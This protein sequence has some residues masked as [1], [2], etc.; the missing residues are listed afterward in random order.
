MERE[1]KIIDAS[2]VVKWFSH[3]E[4]SERALKLR[5]EH[6]SGKIL[7]VA[8]ELIFWEVLN[9]LRY[10]ENNES[11]LIAADR[12]LWDTQLHI[13]KIN[14]F[15]LNKII[16]AAIKYKISIYDS[17]YLTLA[18]LHGCPLI[19]ADKELLKT[20]NAVKV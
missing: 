2:I 13:E 16:S 20:N 17:T 5:E 4:G 8:P 19:T 15:L 1:K 10:K 12:I 11:A 9:A 14:N 18:E 3:E 6:L 7:L